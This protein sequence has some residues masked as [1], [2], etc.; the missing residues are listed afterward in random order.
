MDERR[1]KERRTGAIF[2][3]FVAA[4]NV[5]VWM[6]LV[7]GAQVSGEPA[8]SSEI[9]V[10]LASCFLAAALT[11]AAWLAGRRPSSTGSLSV[12]KARTL[13]LRLALVAVVLNLISVVG[14]LFLRARLSPALAS[15]LPLIAGVW[16]LV[17]LPVQ[18]VAAY[19]TGRGSQAGDRRGPASPA[20]PSEGPGR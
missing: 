5:V 18:L 9:R 15:A 19:A 3:A 4:T 2:L 14:L 1:K 17:V 13:G 11:L 20:P 16:Y 7:S 6:E 8:A 10:A 12:S